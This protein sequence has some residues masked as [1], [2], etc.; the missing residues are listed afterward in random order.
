M[1][2]WVKQKNWSNGKI[3]LTEK[4]VKQK[5]MVRLKNWLNRKMV[6]WK[7]QLNRKVG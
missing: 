2:K 1:E 5:K 4:L 6:K 7:N 3:S